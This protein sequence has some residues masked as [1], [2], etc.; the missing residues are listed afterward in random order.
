ME[1][2]IPGPVVRAYADAVHELRNTLNSDYKINHIFLA[3]GT[4][5]TQAGI[6]AGCKEAGWSQTK[7][8]GISIARQKQSGIDGNT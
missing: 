4:G 3:S 7:V 5:S 6:I 2:V 8:H 1:E